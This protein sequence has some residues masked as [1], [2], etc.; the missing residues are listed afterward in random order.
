MWDPGT[1]GHIACSRTI[2]RTITR[3]VCVGIWYKWHQAG[4]VIV[5]VIVVNN[6]PRE[7]LD[8]GVRR[9]GGA[10]SAPPPA[11]SSWRLVPITCGKPWPEGA[12]QRARQKRPPP[13]RAPGGLFAKS[14]TLSQSD[15]SRALPH[16]SCTL[17]QDDC[18]RALPH[19]S[20]TLNQCD[21]SRALPHS[22]C[23]LTRVLPATA[24]SSRQQ[25]KLPS[26]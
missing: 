8:R 13:R 18:P 17:S 9:S 19:V 11:E 25:S 24:Q 6:H 23:T 15:C 20:C 12:P 4:R 1:N 16:S 22:S 3:P 26:I 14:C 5:R 21:C 10:R 7:A 2:T